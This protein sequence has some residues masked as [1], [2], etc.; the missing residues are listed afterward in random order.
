MTKAEALRIASE[1]A[2]LMTALKAAQA[3]D[4]YAHVERLFNN[5]MNAYLAAT[6]SI[7]TKDNK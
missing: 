5:A 6:G 3:W 4:D 1:Y 7:H 2:N